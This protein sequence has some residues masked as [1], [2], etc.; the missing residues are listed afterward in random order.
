MIKHHILIADD[1]QELLWAMRLVLRSAHYEVSV[2]ADGQKA[3]LYILEA[4][5]RNFPVDLL[6]T[7]IQMPNLTGLE[8]IK[9]LKSRD[10]IVPVIIMTS[11]GN[12]YLDN[13]LSTKDYRGYLNKPFE[14]KKLLESIDIILT[15]KDGYNLS[16]FNCLT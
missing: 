11:N 9:E 10:I 3:L 13:R 12:R 15:E 5:K 7:D 1:E 4:K 16:K 8:L 14:T 6:I 2:V